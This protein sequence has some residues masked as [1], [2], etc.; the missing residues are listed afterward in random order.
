MGASN[1]HLYD[2]IELSSLTA[3]TTFTT[4]PGGGGDIL[5]FVDGA[6]YTDGH[7][8]NSATEI[9]EIN[10]TQDADA[11]R[12]TI[13]G[14]T[15]NIEIVTPS[16]TSNPVTVT[17][18][19]GL[20]TRNLT[21]DD[22]SS[23]VAFI[24]ASPV[25]GGATRYFMVVDD[26]VGNLPDI[27][28]IQIRG[29]DWD[30]AGDDVEINLD[31]NNLITVCFTAGTLIE[32]ED[33]PRAVETIRPGDHVLTLD[34]GPRPVLWTHAMPL[35]FGPGGAP[36]RLGPIRIRRGALGPGRPVRDLLVSPQHRVLVA[37]KA[38]ERLFG[39]AEVLVPAVKLVGAPGIS[40]APGVKRTTY[41]HLFFGTHEVLLAEGALVESLLP[42]REALRALPPAARD[43]LRALAGTAV[44]PARPIV[45]EA[46]LVRELVK[47][48]RK[49]LKPLCDP[50]LAHRVARAASAQTA[51][52]LVGAA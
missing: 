17:Y 3:N 51:L 16:N 24:V 14:V 2:L 20:S 8:G 44:L 21:G 40:R 11:G 41:V 9:V 28:S 5:G 49:N 30:P 37:S 4:A 22:G 46:R 12:I 19:D 15:Y 35:R 32:T 7:S 52:R 13:D 47:R 27:T 45:E 18:N 25:G 48:H 6:T 31:Q 1:T 36:D 34:H 43:S 26:G 42:E 29:L 10:E 50:A 39:V 38:A 33:G 23:Q